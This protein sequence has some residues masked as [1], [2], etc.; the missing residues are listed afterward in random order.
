MGKYEVNMGKYEVNNFITKL[1][2]IT[3]CKIKLKQGVFT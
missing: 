3:F 1:V 2:T